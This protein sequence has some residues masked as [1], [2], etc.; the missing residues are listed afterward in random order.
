MSFYVSK[1]FVKYLFLVKKIQQKKR[2]ATMQQPPI[3]VGNKVDFK[4]LE[5][6]KIL[7][8]FFK[9]IL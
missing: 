9:K 4:I 8:L 6:H 3:C 2:T 5:G 1:I 7:E